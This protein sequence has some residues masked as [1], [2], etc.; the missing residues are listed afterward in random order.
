MKYSLVDFFSDRSIDS[1]ASTQLWIPNGVP[2]QLQIQNPDCGPCNDK[3]R[4]SVL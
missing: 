2:H 4:D 3:A 1:D